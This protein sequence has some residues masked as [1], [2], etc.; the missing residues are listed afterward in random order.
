[1]IR[2]LPRAS[3][4]RMNHAARLPLAGVLIAAAVA[5]AACG[6]TGPSVTPPG[7]SLPA[8]SGSPG[9]SGT[10][11]PSPVDPTPVA[12]QA[13]APG[14]VVTAVNL[15][16]E[17]GAVTV[18]A[19]VPIVLVLDNRDDGIPHDIQ[20]SEANGNVMVKSDI[21]TGPQR[22]M[23]QL[24]ALAPGSYPFV[25]VVHPNMTGTINAE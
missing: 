19:N 20:V 25:C 17:P 24:P 10:V 1:V 23:V 5:L 12:G 2:L 14:I 13:E 16:F 11:L 4:R 21:I 7:P 15:A 6:A 8:A 18:P 9:G 3:S 22:L